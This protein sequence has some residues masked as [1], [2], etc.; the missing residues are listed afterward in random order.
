M[1]KLK[2][3]TLLFIMASFSLIGQTREGY[4]Q[5][6][7]KEVSSYWKTL[8]GENYSVKY[9]SNWELNTSGEMGTK[10]ILL[11]PLPTKME[12]FRANI[13][14]IIQDLEEL[15]TVDASKINL[16]KYV[17]RSLIEIKNQNI[18]SGGELISNDL[19][20]VGGVSHQKIIYTGVSNKGVKLKYEQY[21]WVENN[22]AYVLTL[23]S[24]EYK[25]VDY[26]T[27][28]EKIFDSFRIR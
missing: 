5:K 3:T 15:S 14:L 10:F 20:S 26:Q 23:T 6:P 12:E 8:T 9:P 16:K 22:N 25:F 21:Y 17:E 4:A 24:Q 2:L 1:T 28:A 11:S 7:A 19:V 13:N 18:R 27:T